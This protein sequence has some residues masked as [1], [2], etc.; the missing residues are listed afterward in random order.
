M[1]NDAV[2]DLSRISVPS[3][4]YEPRYEPLQ[5]HRVQQ[6]NDQYPKEVVSHKKDLTHRLLYEGSTIKQ[7]ETFI[8]LELS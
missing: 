3:V 2:T 7:Y 5:N 8:I 6:G 4:G 1:P